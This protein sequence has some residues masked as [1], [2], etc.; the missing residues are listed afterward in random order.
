MR[1]TSRALA[2]A[3]AAALLLASVSVLGWQVS[4]QDASN[5]T[6]SADAATLATTVTPT[7]PPEL[8]GA[9][10]GASESN[11]NVEWTVGEFN[12]ESQ[13]PH[14]FTFAAEIHS[15]AGP[16]SGGRV[17]WTHATGTQRSRPI[18]V[19]PATG[20]LTARWEAGAQDIV[21]PWVG[22]SYYWD[23]ADAAGNR[24]QTDMQY[25]E[26]SDSSRDWLRSESD[27]IIVFSEGLPAEVNDMVI[28]AMARQRETYRAAWGDLLPYKPRA[29]LFGDLDAWVEARITANPR[30]IGRTSSDWGGTA[31]VAYAG[32]LEDLAYGTV[33]HEVAHL[34]QSAFSL[35]SPGTWF[36]EGDATFFE[37]HQMD[38]YEAFVRGLAQQGLLPAL[39]QGTGPG[40]SGE[41]ARW[42]YNIGYTFFKWLT[43]TY[44]LDAHRQLIQLLDQGMGRNEAIER[45][46]GLSIQE[47]ERQWRA[48]LGAAA[49]APTLFPTPT[50]RVFPSPTPFT[51][52]KQ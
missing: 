17:I 5:A 26:Y 3:S 44:G 27:D 52:G 34:Y 21:P 46:T 9:G 4:A 29:I 30:V 25:V 35:F 24:Y 36:I 31:Q 1:K 13:Y 41:R 15:S 38:D 14:G 10:Q 45:V 40:V 47:V 7:A 23:V 48:W 6:P 42:G 28:D 8:Q 49:E 18:E 37:L 33:P 50:M 12:F 2:A 20:R 43:D 32:D 11:A 16:I 19:D 51:F 39:L 22:V